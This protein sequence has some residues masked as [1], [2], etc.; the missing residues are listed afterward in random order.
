MNRRILRRWISNVMVGTMIVAVLVAVL[1][2]ILILGT[3]LVKGAS[4]MNLD[5]F[6]STAL[7]P[8]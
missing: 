5:F 6:T 8:L 2:L 1:P 7:S 3:L 4:S